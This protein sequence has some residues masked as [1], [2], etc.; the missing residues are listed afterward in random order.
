M[1]NQEL[2]IDLGLKNL[3]KVVKNLEGLNKTV[4]KLNTTILATQKQNEE[5]GRTFNN[6]AEN[7][8]KTTE[9]VAK[10]DRIQKNFISTINGVVAGVAALGLGLQLNETRLIAIANRAG[11]AGRGFTLLADNIA[12]TQKFS[13]GLGKALF[14]ADKSV[15]GVAV[16]AGVASAG[17]L[18][19]GNILKDADSEVLSLAGDIS[20]VLGVALGGLSFA[21]TK[22]ILL[23][24]DA[25][26]A[27]GDTLVNAAKNASQAFIDAD[28]KAFIFQSTISGFSMVFGDAVGNTKFWTQAIEDLNKATGETPQKLQAI[29]SEVVATTSQLGFNRQQMLALIDVIQDYAALTG[30]DALQATIDFVSGINGSTQSLIKYG[31]KLQQGVVQQ[32]LLDKGLKTNFKRL[33]NTAKAQTRF[34]LLLDQWQTIGGLATNVSKT[35][36][37]QQQRLENNIARVNNELGKGASIIE[38]SGIQSAILNSVLDNVNDTVLNTIGFMSSLTGR[39]LQVI[40]AFLKW[41]FIIVAVSKA[42]KLLNLV[43]SANAVQ[44]A[45][46][47]SIPFINKSLLELIGLSGATTVSMKTIPGVLLTIGSAAKAQIGIAIRALLGLQGQALST[48]NVLKGSL[49]R[50]IFLVNKALKTLNKSLIFIAKNPIARTFLIIGT[51]ILGVIK[52]IKIIDKETGAISKTLKELGKILF[53][54]VSAFEA[55]FSAIQPL[56]EIFKTGLSKLIGSFVIIVA[57]AIRGLAKLINLLPDFVV[58]QET[59]DQFKDIDKDLE[60]LQDRLKSVG[61]DVRKLG[62]AR[63]VAGGKI[64]F[65]AVIE[66]DPNAIKNLTTQ[67]RAFFDR[68]AD[69]FEKAFVQLSQDENTL[70][71][72][73]SSKLINQQQFEEGS[74]R[75]QKE[76]NNAVFNASQSGYANQITGIQKILSGKITGSGITSVISGIGASLTRSIGQGAEGA[77]SAV[78]GIIGAGLT[79]AFGPVGAFA[80]EVVSLLAQGPE[81]VKETVRAFAAAIPDVLA[82]IIESIPVLIE[83]V[84]LAIP[85]II[86]RL[87]ETLPDVIERAIIALVEA[88]PRIISAIVIRIPFVINKFA[89]ALALQAPKI[90]LAFAEAFIKEI[91]DIAQTFLDELL[92]GLKEGLSDVFQGLGGGLLG[93]N[94]ASFGGILGSAVLGPTAGIAG[95]VG[96][97]LGFAEGGTVPRIPGVSNTGDNVLAGVN[98][99]ELIIP[100]DDL[101]T[102]RNSIRSSEDQQQVQSNM[103]Q[104]I[105]DSLSGGGSSQNLQVNLMLDQEQLASAMF[106][107]DKQGFRLSNG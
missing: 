76:F 13:S 3:N 77:K 7:T 71:K 72:A 73:L 82:A 61:R 22:I 68:T 95:A 66:I 53:N 30:R 12:K 96:G 18:A 104:Q 74:L 21:L 24:G 80:G 2:N 88:A 37:G 8:Q 34:N 99:G 46:A 107:L 41:T 38:D 90:A 6:V 101:Q 81:K 5:L 63:G 87:A 84:A 9:E 62:A 52:A 20:I 19:F 79:K 89:I 75:A 23:A 42:F 56:V 36:A 43:L 32:K 67:V 105:L 86:E 29:V 39:I 103:F 55:L 44:S 92:S 15:L 14:I 28:K 97:F 85:L 17:F 31:V 10:L 102:F 33:S 27:I 64:K 4:D 98:P 1:A 57:G 58:S 45:F 25:A 48:A 106:N 16:N 69:P 49:A 54:G 47:K 50:S 100:G 60:G 35:L 83:E 26:T 91:P 51:V 40:G 65:D 94:D 70:K 93:N 11:F 78:T 59:K